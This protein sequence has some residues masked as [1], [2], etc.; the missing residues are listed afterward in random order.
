M[1]ISTKKT[2]YK[3]KEEKQGVLDITTKSYLPVSHICNF[4]NPGIFYIISQM[5]KINLQLFFSKCNTDILL[6]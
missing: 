4:T 6:A 3:K 5:L 2:T 1:M